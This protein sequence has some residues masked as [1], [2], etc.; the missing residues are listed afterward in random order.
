MAGHGPAWLAAGPPLEFHD[1]RGPRLPLTSPRQPRMPRT[2]PRRPRRGPWPS[3]RRDH[4][5]TATR[6]N[7]CYG[8]IGWFDILHGTDTT[9]REH[10]RKKA[11]ERAQAQAQ[12]EAK[13]AELRSLSA[14]S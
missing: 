2:P 13:V 4:H 10:W 14:Q 11:E 3:P 5:L 1:C 7:C 9:Y 12:W 6:F 8:N